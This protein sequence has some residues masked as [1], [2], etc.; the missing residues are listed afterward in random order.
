MARIGAVILAAG[1]ST[2]LGRPKQFLIHRGQTLLRRAVDAAAGFA[3]IIVVAGRDFH[4][5][6]TELQT[7]RVDLV[8]H[9]QWE[10][11]LGSSIR[12]GVT[13]ILE[14]VP[15]LDSLF[16]LVCDQPYVTTEVLASLQTVRER[17]GK[18]VAACSYAGSFGV[19]ALF[20]R[21]LFPDLLALPDGR[22]AKHV[23][24]KQGDDVSPLAFPEGVIDIDTETEAISHLAP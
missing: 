21:T 20:F 18:A 1:G 10:R 13:R 22:G 11:G 23:I 3:P 24:T 19:P 9:A 6:E 16:I 15:G 5:V 14:L 4:R 12:A 8:H 2:R 17:E 7:A